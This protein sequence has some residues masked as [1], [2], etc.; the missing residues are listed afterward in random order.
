MK[1][2]SILF[3]TI[4]LLIS[5]LNYLLFADD[6]KTLSVYEL[7]MQA[8]FILHGKVKT[9][10][11]KWV[12]GIICTDIEVE[13]IEF[14]KG[15]LNNKIVVRIIGGEVG[16]VGLYATGMPLFEKDEEILIFLREH[17]G[18]NKS[19]FHVV[20]LSQGKFKILPHPKTGEKIAY[21]KTNWIKSENVEDEDILSFNALISSIKKSIIKERN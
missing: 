21:R 16:D 2:K 1:K 20:G 5:S 6:G 15:F 18:E 8:P 14:L 4:V 17:I 10:E 12:E 7:T 3:I 19:K 13:P 9:V 11:S